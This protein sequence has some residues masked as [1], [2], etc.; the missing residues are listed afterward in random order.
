[1]Y[2]RW[3]VWIDAFEARVLDDDWRRLEPLLTEDAIYLVAGAPFACELRGR[4]AVLA[5]FA[6][7][8]RGFDRKF[9]RRTWRAVAPRLAAPNGISARAHGEYFIKGERVIQFSA[10]GQW[11]YRGDRISLMIDTYDL[12]EPDV[13]AALAW[14]GRHGQ[15]MGLD[16]SY[17]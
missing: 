14:L 15:D 12:N 13:T 2:D 9:E 6:K 5:G 8:M 7:S 3:K 17:V 16:A 10:Q 4:D 1:M 11:F